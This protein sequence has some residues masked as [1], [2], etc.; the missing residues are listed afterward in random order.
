[1]KEPSR[2]R[3]LFRPHQPRGLLGQHDKHHLRGIIRKVIIAE[4]PPRRRE[5]PSF[6]AFYQARERRFI[7]IKPVRPK[8]FN[9]VRFHGKYVL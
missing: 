6:V 1:M 3:P 9:V 5:N 2:Q 7:G 4:S 8:Q